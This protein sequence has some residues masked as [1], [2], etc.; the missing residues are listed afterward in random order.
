MRKL[1]KIIVTLA[2]IGLVC[3]IAA[4]AW[5]TRQIGAPS[6]VAEESEILIQSGQSGHDVANML[7]DRGLVTD[8]TLFYVLLRIQ[9]FSIKAGEYAIP[10]HASIKDI[11][12]VLREGKTIQREFTLAEGLTVKQALILL[13]QNELLTGEI[14]E[15]PAEGSLLP[16]T[17]SFVRGEAR[18]ALIKRMQDALTKLLDE[19]W[20]ARD[21][22]LPLKS[23][24]EA[25]ILAS[26]VEKETGKA[27]ERKKI[28][29]LF[30]NRLKIGMP[31]Q[32][33]PTIVY[34]VTDGLGHMGGKA[35]YKK[36]LNIDSPYNTYRVT[37]LPPTPIANPGRAALEAVFAPEKHDY[38]YFVADG[39]G[40]HVFSTTLNEHNKNVVKWR[41]IKKAKKD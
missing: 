27:E 12:G 5:V 18:D 7:A 41:K 19:L 38:L 29:G 20:A 22:V 32:T 6:P 28:A 8:A 17:Y 25:V 10:P 37:G 23:K 4:G 16:D 39:T 14:K 30:Y 31:L 33:D 24:E 35:I 13:Q 40:S 9:P 3:L 21:P 26:I 36:D 2:S 1:L 15:M 34:A 11:A